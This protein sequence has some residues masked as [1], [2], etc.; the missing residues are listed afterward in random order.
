MHLSVP[1]DYNKMPLVPMGCAVR[2]HK[3]TDK[4]GIWSSHTVDEWYL[5]T[6]SEHYRTHLCHI[7]ET[8]S[9]RLTDTA[10]FSHKNITKPTITH[11]D[12]IMAAIAE[13]AKTIK[14]M[15]NEN[16]VDEMEQLQRLIERVIATNVEVANKMLSLPTEQTHGEVRPALA[17]KGPWQESP[18][19]NQ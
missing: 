2:V 18:D 11:A 9:E 10:Q 5:A 17:A 1:F 13:C 15:G 8:R 14:G 6:L 12:K 3:K 16:G 4:R 7:K 19:P